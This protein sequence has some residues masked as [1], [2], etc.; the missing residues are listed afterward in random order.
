MREKPKDQRQDCALTFDGI[1]NQ[2]ET[3]QPALY[4]TYS[5]PQLTVAL[6]Q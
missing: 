1:N 5:L 3:G 2:R 6:V 4:N